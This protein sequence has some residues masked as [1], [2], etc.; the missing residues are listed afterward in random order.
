MERKVPL[1]LVVH[2]W[3]SWKLGLGVCPHMWVLY[4]CIHTHACYK[5]GNVD[6]PHAIFFFFFC[7]FIHWKTAHSFHVSSLLWMERE[8]LP[9]FLYLSL[10]RLLTKKKETSSS[11]PF[12]YRRAERLRNLCIASTY[13]ILRH[14]GWMKRPVKRVCVRRKL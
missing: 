1:S 5:K 3:G 4:T 12:S 8:N 13:L 6:P 14:L 10:S 2:G 7:C 9:S 11:D